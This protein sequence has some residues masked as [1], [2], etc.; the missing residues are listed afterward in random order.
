MIFN[1]RKQN[2]TNNL[3]KS[4]HIILPTNSIMNLSKLSI[5]FVRTISKAITVTTLNLKI[6]FT[7]QTAKYSKKYIGETSKNLNIQGSF[8]KQYT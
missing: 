4:S 1:V 5:K 2:I 6:E 3:D 8:T 7:K